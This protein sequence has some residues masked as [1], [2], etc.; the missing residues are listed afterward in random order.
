[1]RAKRRPDARREFA[2]EGATS[3]V[4]DAPIALADVPTLCVSL[5]FTF[6]EDDTSRGLVIC[7][8]AFH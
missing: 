2:E 3:G 1:M 4:A 6:I 8:G 7:K 5:A